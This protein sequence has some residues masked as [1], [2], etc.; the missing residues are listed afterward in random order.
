VEEIMSRGGH[1]FLTTRTEVATDAGERVVTV[2]SRLVV[3]GEG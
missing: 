3:R 2:W 1:D